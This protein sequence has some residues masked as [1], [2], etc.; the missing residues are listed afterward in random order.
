MITVTKS[1]LPNKEKLFHYIDKIYTSGQLTNHGPLVQELENRLA[2]YLKVSHLILVANG[3]LALQI[4]YKA[5]NIQG[6]VITTPF[7][8][9]ATTSSLV[10]ESLH[11]IFVDIDRHDWNIDPREIENNITLH[12]SAIVS[13]HVFGNACQMEAIAD[14]AKQYSL[15]IIY[16]GAHAFDVT[17]DNQSL[18]NYGDATTLSF[19]ATKLFHTIEG[20]AIITNDA[21]LAAKIRLMI[22]F[23]IASPDK[24]TTLGINAKMNEFQAAMG[25]CMLDEI[26][27][28]TA[29][30]KER[31]DYYETHLAECLTLQMRHVK[32]SNNYHYFPV[33][34]ADE[35]Q[36]KTIQQK[37]NEHLIFPRRYFYPILNELPYILDKKLMPNA[38]D[39][40]N[41][42]LCLPLYPDLELTMMKKICDLIRE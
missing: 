11:P 35:P 10:W 28:I 30:R 40:S 19:H 38:K 39:I 6:S 18:L 41:R 8:F 20:G 36:R 17:Y 31:W 13:T 34:F 14:I 37:L 4:A 12:T 5:L 15:K 16:D 7:S 23:G 2:A 42:I 25:L 29:L 32:C 1:Y 9:S 24:I 21:S 26:P 3:T 27:H 33:L 22:N